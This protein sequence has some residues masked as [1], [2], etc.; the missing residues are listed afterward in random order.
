MRAG[1]RRDFWTVVSPNM[2]PLQGVISRGDAVFK[3]A[4]SL[5]QAERS[6]LL[7]ETL[8]R[9][10]ARYQGDASEVTFRVIVSP[11]VTWVWLGALVVFLG[12]LISLWP[13]PASIRRRVTSA[14]AARLG[15]EL[16]RA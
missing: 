3:Q 12:G 13:A 1:L 15:R 16:G 2:E 6:A 11:L 4:D 8:R 10:V 14:Y 5:P 7:G 9:L